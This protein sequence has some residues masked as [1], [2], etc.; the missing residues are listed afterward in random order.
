MLPSAMAV[1]PCLDTAAC[2]EHMPQLQRVEPSRRQLDGHVKVQVRAL[3]QTD[4]D[5]ADKRWCVTYRSC[6]DARVHLH[7]Q[8]TD[9]KWQLEG[10]PKQ[11]DMCASTHL[12]HS[13]NDI[14][15]VMRSSGW[16]HS[17]CITQWRGHADWPA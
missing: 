17:G 5:A 2:T 4:G 10:P 13:S 7:L 12:S 15:A 3:Q 16:D 8:V 6:K 14:G 1:S 9:F 11:L